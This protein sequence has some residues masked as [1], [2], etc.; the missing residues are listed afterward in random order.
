[1][2]SAELPHTDALDS[3]GIGC[4]SDVM[5]SIRV[6]IVDD[7]EIFR[8]G[9][10]TLLSVQPDID[11]VDEVASGQDAITR[12]MELQPDVVVMDI[13]LPGMSGVE[14]TRE[15]VRASPHMGVLM[16]TM[17]EDDDSL[18]EALRGGARGYLL[19]SDSSREI[20]DAVRLGGGPA[21]FSK[22]IAQR[23][24]SYFS[25]PRASSVL[26]QLTDREREILKLIAEGVNNATIARTLYVSPKTVRNHISNI[27]SKLQVDDRAQAIV[28]ARRAGLTDD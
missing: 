21:V 26:P 15:I 19:K 28:H 9:L 14:A 7:H 22:G 13:N 5:E 23:V 6:L 3:S 4:E 20:V 16:L 11:V 1:M 17:Q 27:F 8:T 24:I 12:A 18:F 2:T 25:A 10:R